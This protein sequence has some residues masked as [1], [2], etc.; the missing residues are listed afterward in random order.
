MKGSANGRF[1]L[2]DVLLCDAQ[3]EELSVTARLI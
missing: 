2:A 1:A 3:I